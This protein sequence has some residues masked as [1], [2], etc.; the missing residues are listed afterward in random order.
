MPQPSVVI[1]PDRDGV[2]YAGTSLTLTCMVSLDSSVDTP[3]NNVIIWSGPRAIPGEWYTVTDTSG[4]E[5]LYSW[6]LSISPLAKG[7][8]DGEYSCTVVVGSG[9]FPSYIIQANSSDSTVINITSKIL[10]INHRAT[11]Y[12]YCHV[13]DPPPLEVNI[14]AS[15]LPLTGLG[16]EFE[17]RASVVEDLIPL[18]IIELMAPNEIPLVEQSSSSILQYSF[19]SLEISDMGEYTCIANLTIPGSGIDQLATDTVSLIVV[20]M[21]VAF[22]TYN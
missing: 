9:V 20:G 11:V 15:G 16:Y 19:D 17:C 3:L 10:S 2:L 22:V 1:N 8:D 4:I 13:S 14:V 18:L 12:E 21:Y 6:N 7:R 5:T